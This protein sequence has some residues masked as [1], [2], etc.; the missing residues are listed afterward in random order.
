MATQSKTLIPY[1][2]VHHLLQALLGGVQRLLGDWFVGLYLGGLLAVGD[3][4]P[5]YNDIDFLA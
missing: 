1:L 3:F 2:D 4:D 5:Q